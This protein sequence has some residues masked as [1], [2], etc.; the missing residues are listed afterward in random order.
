MDV[1]EQELKSALKNI[2]EMRSK[3]SEAKGRFR[4]LDDQPDSQNVV[5]D[6]NTV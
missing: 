4:V 3:Q 5:T 1:I 2:E 6:T